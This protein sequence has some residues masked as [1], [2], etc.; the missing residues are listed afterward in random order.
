MKCPHCGAKNKNNLRFCSE[1]GM[2]LKKNAK[3]MSQQQ[4]DDPDAWEKVAKAAEA[5]VAETDVQPAPAPVD[6]I[7]GSINE[8]PVVSD[9]PND[10]P[11]APEVEPAIPVAAATAEEPAVPDAPE[12]ARPVRKYQHPENFDR[13]SAPKKKRDEEDGSYA[14]I[15]SDEPIKRSRPKEKSVTPIIVIAA[16]LLFL[17]VAGVTGYFLV[18]QGIIFGGNTAATEASTYDPALDPTAVKPTLPPSTKA[19]EPPTISHTTSLVTV[20]N[21][22][23]KSPEEAEKLLEGMGFTVESSKGYDKKIAKGKVCGQDP[24]AGLAVEPGSTIKIVISKGPKATEST[25]KPTQKPT[26]K[27][28]QK[29]TEKKKEKQ[30]ST[31][32]PDD[33]E[34][35]TD[36]P[37]PA[38]TDDSYFMADTA[39][40][41]IKADELK[42]Y[43]NADLQ[44]A[45]NEI[46]ARHGLI[47]GNN[48]YKDYFAKK[49]WY[50]GD[51]KSYDVAASRFN[52][53]ENA[54]I[55]TLYNAKKK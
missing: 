14:Y 4:L 15:D 55:I 5:N 12:P 26:Q 1:C 9:S 45:I 42:G 7:P 38:G 10:T 18:T 29:P 54:N 40:R 17:A 50:K 49:S 23:G 21:V 48:Q 31:E 44:L 46:Y 3:I 25:E 52:E 30:K 13:V 2:R 27:A 37:E 36:A 19:T 22:V 28:T 33:P 43:S 53:Y 51:T 16:I 39:T 41:Y 34:P 11:V 32:A 24:P 20:P 8:E 6:E 35:E 47:F